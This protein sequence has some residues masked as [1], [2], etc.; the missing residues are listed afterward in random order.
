M[1]RVRLETRE[2]KD[3]GRIK[4]PEEFEG[5]AVRRGALW[6]GALFP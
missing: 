2:S 3:S 6:S 1:T 4:A 5:T